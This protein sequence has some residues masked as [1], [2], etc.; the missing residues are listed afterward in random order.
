MSDAN[1]KNKFNQVSSI[2]EKE[3]ERIDDT[4]RLEL[5]VKPVARMT[6]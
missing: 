1:T 3:S 2:V 6:M 4:I 5:Y